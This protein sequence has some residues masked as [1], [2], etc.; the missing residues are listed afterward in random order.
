MGHMDLTPRAFRLCDFYTSPGSLL[1]LTLLTSALSP[2]NEL[3]HTGFQY[4]SLQPEESLMPSH[5]PGPGGGKGSQ[6]P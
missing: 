5:S 4:H 2:T 3:I 1:S 6:I